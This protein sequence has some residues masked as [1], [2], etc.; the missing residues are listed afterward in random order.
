MRKPSR[1]LRI[2]KWAGAILCAVIVALLVYSSPWMKGPHAWGLNG[3]SSV[4]VVRN[5][6]IVV[7]RFK[8]PPVLPDGRYTSSIGVAFFNAN[9]NLPSE[10]VWWPLTHSTSGATLVVVPLWML[11]GLFLVPTAFL[12]WRDRN[13]RPPGHC[14]NC[15]YDLTGNTSGRCPECGKGT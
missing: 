15:G 8:Q 13:R 1:L 10:F 3:I 6:G 12:W 2:A 9:P 5:G 7:Q 4:I 11:L 14:R